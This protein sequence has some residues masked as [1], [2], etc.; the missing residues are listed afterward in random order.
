MAPPAQN[1]AL[2]ARTVLEV[3]DGLRWSDPR[4][5][6]SLAEHAVR[7]AGDDAAVRTAA[8]RS[9]IRS[10]AEVDRFDEVVSRAT[11]L[12]EEV[13]VNRDRDGLAG[14]PMDGFIDGA[15]GALAQAFT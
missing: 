14:A 6:A 7:L 5:G 8:E 1:G 3:A 11:P 13:A 10:L 4:L 15:E 12:V 9:V 2:S